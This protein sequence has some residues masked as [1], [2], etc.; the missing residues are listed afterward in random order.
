MCSLLYKLKI[1][2]L[3]TCCSKALNAL[4]FSALNASTSKT[5]SSLACLSRF[6]LPL[7]VNLS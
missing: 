6:V 3:F 7:K 2:N 1:K 5:A 4:S